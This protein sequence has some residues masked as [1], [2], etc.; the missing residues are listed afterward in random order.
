MYSF[1][2]IL[3]SYL[4]FAADTWLHIATSTVPFTILKPWSPSII[5]NAYGRGINTTL[6]SPTGQYRDKS[7]IPSSNLGNSAAEKCSISVDH[8]NIY[9]TAEHDA[10][11]TL[12][13]ISTKHYIRSYTDNSSGFSWRAAGKENVF[14]FLT[15]ADIDQKT[16]FQATS[17][18]VTT[19]CAPISQKCKL[20]M[21]AL[22]TSVSYKCSSGFAGNS[23]LTA[24]ARGGSRY[25]VESHYFFDANLSRPLVGNSRSNGADNATLS[26][27]PIYSAHVGFGG[28]L[29][30][31]S[32][33]VA[34]NGRNNAWI[35]GCESTVVDMTFLWRNQVVT[36][37]TYTPSNESLGGTI[38]R[39][40]FLDLST[41]ALILVS[42]SASS[43]TP[44]N[45][46]DAMA[47]AISREMIGLNVGIMEPRTN[48]QE[49]TRE[50]FLVARVPVAPLYSLIALTL[51][52]A[53]VGMVL[54]VVAFKS[55]LGETKEV[56][57]RLTVAGVVAEAFEES[58]RVRKRVRQVDD[59]FAERDGPGTSRRIGVVPAEE[60]GWR[61]ELH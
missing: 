18:G 7:E 41:V 39:P 44:S 11:L 27:N 60:G 9:L 16:D 6:C 1:T 55:A 19:T 23:S 52:Y 17:I 42:L 33:I 36:N 45:L 2:L 59:L 10:T 14:N 20:Y 46:A 4:I 49:Q 50:E 12:T 58:E 40:M 13:N 51:L 28:G 43:S 31:N 3:G 21:D 30:T 25:S 54:A 61:F 32:D 5:F 37:V 56:Q 8:G 48:L 38:V 35:L 15:S 57:A 24:T 34:S 26:I 22:G 53:I 47:N 29:H